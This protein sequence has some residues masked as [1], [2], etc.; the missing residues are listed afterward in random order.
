VEANGVVEIGEKTSRVRNEIDCG[1]LVGDNGMAVNC[2]FVLLCFAAEDGMIFEDKTFGAGARLSKKKGCC[3]EPADS[4]A[5]HH[6]IVEL[7]RVHD[8]F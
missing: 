2:E 8:V 3:G 7:S 1:T 6:A 5:D 4:S